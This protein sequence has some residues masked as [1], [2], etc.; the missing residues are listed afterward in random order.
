VCDAYVP[1]VGH[2]VA[3]VLPLPALLLLN[4][5]LNLILRL[6]LLLLLIPILLGVLVILHLISKR[7]PAALGAQLTQHPPQLLGPE[8]VLGRVPQQA[9][10]VEPLPQD[11]H[12]GGA[13]A[14]GVE[15]REVGEL[16]GRVP[17]GVVGGDVVGPVGGGAATVYGEIDR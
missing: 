3:T 15:G 6:L 10:R 11:G 8:R 17:A 14:G 16:V 13:A 5:I 9:L 12:L 4:L 7:L 1:L 2:L